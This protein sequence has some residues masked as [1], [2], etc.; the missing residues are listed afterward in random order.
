MTQTR[1]LIV[2][3]GAIKQSKCL[4]YPLI[5]TSSPFISAAMRAS[6]TVY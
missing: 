5:H 4:F 3:T 2:Y 1:R 6:F